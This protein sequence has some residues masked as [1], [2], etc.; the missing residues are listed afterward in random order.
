MRKAN[1]AAQPRQ[2]MRTPQEFSHFKHEREC[3]LAEKADAYRQQIIA[4]QRVLP[5]PQLV[6]GIQADFSQA[7]H[8]QKMSQQNGQIQAQSNVT[9]TGRNSASGVINGTSPH[10]TSSIPSVQIPIGHPTQN[11]PLPQPQVAT[12]G[13]SSLA[14]PQGQNGPIGSRGGQIP[15]AP[16]QPHMQGQQR[17]PSQMSPDNMRVF[18]EAS[19]LQQEQQR[20]L[21]QQRQNQSHTNSQGSVLSSPP[22]PGNLS[23][24]NQINNAAVLANLQ[25]S[26]G[27]PSPAVSGGAGHSRS[28]ASPRMTNSM[29]AQPLSSG[30]IPA[31]NQISND[32]KARHPQA[33]P[34]QV[35]KMTT[36]SLNRY[37]MTQSQAAMQAA[38]GNT[39]STGNTNGL[40]VPPQQP[41]MTSMLDPRI[42]AQ[43]MR[44]QQSS[45]QSRNGASSVNG[46]QPPSRGAATPQTSRNTNGQ[47]GPNQSPRPPQAQIAGPQ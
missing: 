39:V 21:Q 2:R 22:I 7:T 18:L 12:N 40:Q 38:A 33:S 46:V 41:A 3:K 25:A 27:V 20:Y 11:R 34:E 32:I 37:R 6:V 45:Q 17:V 31:V 1:E 5:G 8:I 36:D 13:I 14:N 9:Q 15:P 10:L 28:S 4:Q 26:N 16:M 44:S 23:A 43:M 24:T 35:S 30:M 47:A 42:Y 29:Q 19:R